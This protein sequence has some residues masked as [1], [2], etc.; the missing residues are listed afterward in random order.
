MTC[1]KGY[2]IWICC[3]VGAN[4]IYADFDICANKY[5]IGSWS[6]GF[7]SS[8]LGVLNHLSWCADN[9]RIP[10]IYWGDESLYYQYGGYNG[11]ENAWEYY[12]KPVSP[13]AASKNECRSMAYAPGPWRFYFNRLDSATRTRAKKLIDAYIQLANPVKEKIENFYNSRMRGKKTIGIHLRGTDKY[14]EVKPVPLTVFFKEANNRARLLGKN[15]QFLVATD[16]AALLKQAQ[17]KLNRPVIFYTC[18]RSVNKM[19]LHQGSHGASHQAI[20]GEDV[21]I[22]AQLLARC[23]LFIHSLSN[24]SAAVAYFN[25]ELPTVLLT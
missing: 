2:L 7:F 19:P 14:T 10:A 18:R 21:L 11:K 23:N 17:Q 8:F 1:K 6:G 3:V 13:C 25:P 16:E 24:V 20:L 5:V 12:F 22:E 9:G 15:C 4:F